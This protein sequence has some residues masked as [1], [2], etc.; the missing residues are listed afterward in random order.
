[1]NELQLLERFMALCPKGT[2][3]RPLGQAG[4]AKAQKAGEDLCQTKK[5]ATYRTQKAHK[6]RRGKKRR[7]ASVKRKE[8]LSRGEKKGI[9]KEKLL[10]H[11]RGR[12]GGRVTF[13]SLRTLRNIGPGKKAAP[14]TARRKLP[15]GRPAPRFGSRSIP[16]GKTPSFG[17]RPA[18]AKTGQREA[19]PT[20]Q[21][22]NRPTP[23][24]KTQIRNHFGPMQILKFA[25]ELKALR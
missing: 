10:A 1:M 13:K 14:K 2:R 25:R 9:A 6:A 19:R 20:P 12:K 11:I 17:S 15:K 18:P 16:K 5:G 7:K 23:Q 22:R 4:L 8:F 3:G 24:F 21:F